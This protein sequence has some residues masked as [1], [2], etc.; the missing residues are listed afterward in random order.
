MRYDCDRGWESEWEWEW[1]D[2][3]EAV[4]TKTRTSFA[5]NGRWQYK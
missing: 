5:S 1:E 2:E 3:D 4:T